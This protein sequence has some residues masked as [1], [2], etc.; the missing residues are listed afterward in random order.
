MSWYATTRFSLT[1]PIYLSESYLSPQ[2][3]FHSHL[4]RYQTALML[5]SQNTLQKHLVAVFLW[6]H[7]TEWNPDPLDLLD[8]SLAR[9]YIFFFKKSS[10]VLI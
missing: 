9:G 8:H 1:I 2:F 10:Q 4:A 7:S 5:P 3:R 6:D